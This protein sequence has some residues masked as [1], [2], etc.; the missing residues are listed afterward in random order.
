MSEQQEHLKNLLDQQK[1]L[2]QEIQEL[3]RSMISKKEMVLKIQ[4]VLEYLQQIGVT[5]EESK[6]VEESKED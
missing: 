4:G 2:I 5:L 3:E 1:V 6:E